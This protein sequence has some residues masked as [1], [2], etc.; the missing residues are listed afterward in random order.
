[1]TSKVQIRCTV[2]RT[3]KLDVREIVRRTVP[4]PAYQQEALP[5]EQFAAHRAANRRSASAASRKPVTQVAQGS[6]HRATRS[7]T[8]VRD[9]AK[10]DGPGYSHP[11]GRERKATK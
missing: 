6:K 3:T 7:M 5:R 10:N 4:H 8:I 11:V 1:M 2:Q 9:L